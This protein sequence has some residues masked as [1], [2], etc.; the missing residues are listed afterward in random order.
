MNLYYTESNGTSALTQ[1]LAS[2]SV[3]PGTYVPVYGSALIPQ[4]NNTDTNPNAYID[5][6]FQIPVNTQWDI[7]TVMVTPTGSTAL[8]TQLPYDQAS[9]Y[10]QIDHLYHVEYPIVP[11]GTIIDFYGFNAPAHYLLCDGTNTYSRVQYQQLFQALTLVLNITQASS[12]TF[13]GDATKLGIGMYV[14]GAGISVGT[15]ITGISAYTAGA[16]ITV[17]PSTTSTGTISATFFA[18]GQGDGS[19]T[20]ATPDLRGYV[21]AGV[22]GTSLFLPNTT[23]NTLGAD[24]G[25]ATS[26]ALINHTHPPASTMTAFYGPELLQR[27]I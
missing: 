3:S 9:P 7:S 19:T 17:S 12:T 16:T 23:P 14:E 27:Q 5:I 10:R 20:F 8:T 2:Q 4:S 22:G 21:V 26:S 18:A 13:T 1:L 6:Y 24:V 25:A 15:S 11:V